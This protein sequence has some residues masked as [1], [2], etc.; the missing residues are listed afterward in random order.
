QQAKSDNEAK[1]TQSLTFETRSKKDA[2]NPDI[3]RIFGFSGNK[4]KSLN[5]SRRD[6]SYRSISRKI[7]GLNV[8]KR[9]I[10]PDDCCMSGCVNCVWELFNEDM[11]EWKLMTKQAVERLIAQGDDIKEQWPKGFDPP[12]ANLPDKYIP[13]ELKQAKGTEDK[14][15]EMPLGLQVFAN[16]EKKKKNKKK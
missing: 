5:S 8:L 15:G 7:C 6:V 10:E 14:R 11:Q 1:K 9:P 2:D 12:P 13:D 4:N 3:D 16:F